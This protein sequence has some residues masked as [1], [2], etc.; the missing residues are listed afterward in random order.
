MYKNIYKVSYKVMKEKILYKL[1]LVKQN[2]Q[3]PLYDTSG[4]YVALYK[5]YILYFFYPPQLQK[6][7]FN[8]IAGEKW[9]MKP[10][11]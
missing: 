11:N 3:V 4:H 2:E 9:L 8:T 6:H 7:S 1:L 10:W 5:D